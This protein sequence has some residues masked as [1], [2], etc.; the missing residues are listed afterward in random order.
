MSV[1][2]LILYHTLL[3]RHPTQIN[4]GLLFQPVCSY[5]DNVVLSKGS[6]L[7]RIAAVIPCVA[8][9]GQRGEV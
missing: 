8:L 3:H 2:F 4:L 1:R 7:S 9:A 6:T 5:G